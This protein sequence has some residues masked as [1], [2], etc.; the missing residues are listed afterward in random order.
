MHSWSYLI[1]E[2]KYQGHYLIHLC[3]ADNWQ[4]LVHKIKAGGMRAGV[5]LRPGTPIEE[6]YPLV[7]EYSVNYFKTRL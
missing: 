7:C 6:V 5:A 1:L 2:T 4:E 3:G